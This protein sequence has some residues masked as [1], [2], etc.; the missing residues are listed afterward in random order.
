MDC[1][2][3]RIPPLPQLLTVGHSRWTVGM[4]HFERIF[5]V[6]DLL[7]VFDGTL[8]MS[9]NGIPYSINAGEL[10]LLE[11]G[12]SHV[13]HLPCT[14]TTDI[15]WVHFK[16]DAPCQKMPVKQVAW[17]TRIR[18]GTDY[19]LTPA[20][21]FLYLPKY[22][23]FEIETLKKVLDDM[24]RLRQTLTMEYAVDMQ[25]LFGRL[26][27]VLQ[28]GLRM[29]RKGSRSYL[30]AN[31]VMTYLRAHLANPFHAGRMAEELHF[32]ED[33]SAR[34]LRKHTGMSPM[35]Y[36]HMLRMEEAKQLLIYSDRSLREIADIIGYTDYNYFTRIFKR[37]IG[38]T[39]SMFRQAS[40]QYM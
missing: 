37:T 31:K 24:L 2:Q 19:D 34:C 3:L 4:Q 7:M 13:G 33:Y 14:E 5:Q 10:L 28:S 8:H 9:E 40:A 35:K 1:V 23:S 16:H 6:Y 38:V 21:Q 25:V 20:E 22:G 36:H 12:L 18:E 32:D 39:P 17:S 15:Y 26:L 29:E 27:T 30:V 11:P